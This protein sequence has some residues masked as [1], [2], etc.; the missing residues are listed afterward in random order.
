M[1]ST[2]RQ[3]QQHE[4]PLPPLS[5]PKAT[6]A[7]FLEP[8]PSSTVTEGSQLHPPPLSDEETKKWGTHIMGPP[9]A[10]N[11]HPDNR[12]AALWVAV[13]YQQIYY[14]MNGA[15]RQ[16]RQP[17]T[18]GTTDRLFQ[19][20]L[21]VRYVNLTARALTEGGFESLFILIFEIDPSEK[22]EK[23]SACY[24]S[25]PTGPVAGSLYLSICSSGFLQ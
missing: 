19:K 9:P 23:T 4:V 7:E 12:Q 18:S 5:A 22:L 17:V 24:L 21:G 15:R 16:R 3:T 8:P 11:V 1:T 13:E 6:G 2:P 25:T 10:P 14:S 20:L